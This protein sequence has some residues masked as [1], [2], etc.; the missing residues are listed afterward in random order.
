[1]AEQSGE[2]SFDATPHRRQQAREKGQIAYSQ[3]LGSA[4]LLLVAAGL[5]RGMG[6]GIVSLLTGILQ[7]NLG[8]V[9]PLTGSQQDLVASTST[10]IQT[11]TLT[12]LP[13]LL[14]LVL[15]GVG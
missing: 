10:M 5:L 15:A 11:I 8:E 13:M 3:D 4:A 14:L 12:L 9:G 7:H 6:G 2:K 1:M